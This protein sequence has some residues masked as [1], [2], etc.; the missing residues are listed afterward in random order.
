M[1]QC[2]WHCQ[3]NSCGCSSV[4]DA[5]NHAAINDPVSV[6]LSTLQLWMPQCQGDI[7]INLAAMD[8]P[9]SVTLSTLQLWMLQCHW[10]CQPCSFGCSNVSDIVDPALSSYGYF[11][12]RLSVTLSTLQ[13]WMLQCQWHCE[14][15]S[16]EC[17]SVNPAAMDAPVSM[18]LSTLQLWML[19]CP[20]HWSI[21][22]CW[23]YTTKHPPP[24][25]KL[26]INYLKKHDILHL[27]MKKK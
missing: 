11:S 27:V 15:C 7:S 16:F 20:W 14:P 18:T 1:L 13:L 24:T 10:H 9:V 23:V 12:V 19:Q 4:T 3:P 25:N 17:S 6:S 5:V 21:H 22:S 26:P 8:A 2:Q